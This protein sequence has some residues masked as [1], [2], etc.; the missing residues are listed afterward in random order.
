MRV[1][2]AP[3]RNSSPRCPCPPN[4]SRSPMALH[5]HPRYIHNK[6]SVPTSTTTTSALCSVCVSGS[7]FML[8]RGLCKGRRR[9]VKRA[10]KRRYG[11]RRPLASAG[12]HLPSSFSWSFSVQACPLEESR[13]GRVAPP[14][15]A[16]CLPHSGMSCCCSFPRRTRGSVSLPARH[17]EHRPPAHARRHRRRHPRTRCAGRATNWK[18]RAGPKRTIRRRPRRRCHGCPC[19]RRRC[20]CHRR[21]WVSCSRRSE[22]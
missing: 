12:M 10:S 18:D 11:R 13:P 4:L 3:R 15:A 1:P 17:P 9:L 5:M 6:Q 14:P 20:C 21:R 22:R 8:R 16:G 2:Y 7:R 19:R